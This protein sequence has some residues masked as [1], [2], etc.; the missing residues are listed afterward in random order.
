[1]VKTLEEEVKERKR[2][3][4][5]LEFMAN[6]DAL[7][8]LPGL[9]LCR[10]RME[11]AFVESRIKQQN[12][13][14][15]FI[16]LDGFKAVN[17]TFGHEFGDEVLKGTAGRIKSCLRETDTVAR[18]GGDE[19]IVILPVVS[20]KTDVEIIANNLNAVISQ[21][22]PIADQSITISASIGITI[23]TVDDANLKELIRSA[24]RAMFDVKREGK[25]GF[26]FAE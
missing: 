26:K 9:R 2:V 13:G 18:I 5:E 11:H 23:Y 7:T 1:M 10:E 16:D 14:V 12:I 25:K 20:N 8:G 4:D 17:D 21:S 19:F 24:D 22:M 6:H 15:M 3:S